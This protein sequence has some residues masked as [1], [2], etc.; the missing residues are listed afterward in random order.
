[1]YDGLMYLKPQDVVVLIKL[2][3]YG[4][5]RPPYAQIAKELFLSASEVHASVQ[6]AKRAHLLGG[7]ESR[8]TP[9][10]SAMEEFLIHGLKYA[11]PPQ[12]GE[13]TRGVPTA[14]GAEPLKSLI[15]PG[16]DPPPV[17][18]FPEGKTRGYSFAPLYKTVPQAAL[19]DSFLYEMLALIDSIRD[20][21]TRE[22]HIAEEELKVRLR[23][24]HDA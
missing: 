23:S 10:K 21:R 13:L 2:L 3:G 7:T 22:R 19:R 5:K 6:R 1:M 4:P 16:N 18:P 14:F 8:E 12:R 17:W 24:P 11:F 9:N 20:G 15:S